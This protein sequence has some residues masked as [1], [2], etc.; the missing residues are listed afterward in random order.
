[1][2]ET[3]PEYLLPTRTGRMRIL[4]VVVLIVV[5]AALLGECAGDHARAVKVL[6]YCQKAVETW[7][8]LLGV[9]ALV[10]VAVFWFAWRAA[11]IFLHDQDPPPR[12]IVFWPRRMRRGA[13]ATLIGSLHVL[14]AMALVLVVVLGPGDLLYALWPPAPGC[15]P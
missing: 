5:A 12:T 9:A 13:T 1:M 8:M 6:A 10:L 11:R 7:R 3:S 4:A 15:A 2:P 14:F